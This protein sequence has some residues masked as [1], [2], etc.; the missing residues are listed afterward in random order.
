[1]FALFLTAFLACN[2]ETTETTKKETTQ[3]A[4][5]RAYHFFLTSKVTISPLVAL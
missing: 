5:R 1:M 4:N 2:S 3:K